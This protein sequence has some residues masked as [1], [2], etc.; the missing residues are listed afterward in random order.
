MNFSR[1]LLALLIVV[2]VLCAAFAPASSAHSAAI[3]V[4]LCLFCVI[5]PAVQFRRLIER[6]SLPP[7]PFCPSLASRPPPNW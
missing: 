4:S 3:L 1:K 7:S 5:L 2:A 6:C